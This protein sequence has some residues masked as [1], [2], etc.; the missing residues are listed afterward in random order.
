MEHLTQNQRKGIILMCVIMLG[1]IYIIP[2]NPI[3]TIL[4]IIVALLMVSHIVKLF[5]NRN[6]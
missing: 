2:T 4:A 5:L 3:F 6:K 1:I